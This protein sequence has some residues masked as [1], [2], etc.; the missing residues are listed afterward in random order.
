M[1]N[2]M[3]NNQ[4][5]RRALMSSTIVAGLAFATPAFAQDA[6][7]PEE[8]PPEDQPTMQSQDAIEDELAIRQATAGEIVVTGSRI[9]RPNLEQSA[10]VTVVGAEEI[11]LQQPTSAED[12]L[13]EIPGASPATGPQTNNGSNGSANV[14]LRGLGTNRNLVLL[15]SRRVTPRDITA[16]VDLNMIPVTMIERTDVYTGGASTVY[17]ADAVAGVV[18]FITRRDFAGAE[19]GALYGITERGTESGTAPTSPL[20]RI[21]TTAAATPCSASATPRQ[22]R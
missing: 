22:L 10:P 19:I 13:R 8:I 7:P 12:F 3:P 17:G 6:I 18:N 21:S 11:A 20:A 4:L 9:A 2:M 1:G 15:N 14:N 16:V 5:L